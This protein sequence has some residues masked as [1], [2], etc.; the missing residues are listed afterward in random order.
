MSQLFTLEDVSKQST[1]KGGLIIIDKH[2]YDITDYMPKHPGGDDILI[3]VLGRDAS[4]G[5]HEV[6][7][8]AEAMEELKALK[9]GELDL[10]PAQVTTKGPSQRAIVSASHLISAMGVVALSLGAVFLRHHVQSPFGQ[11]KE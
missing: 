3:E 10:T 5:F 6:G 1:D 11:V 4:E 2:V 9:V 8:S 7:H